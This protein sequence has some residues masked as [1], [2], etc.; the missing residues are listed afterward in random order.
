MFE[1]SRNF[2]TK[3]KLFDDLLWFDSNSLYLVS[4]TIMYQIGNLL[5]VTL[6]KLIVTITLCYLLEYLILGVSLNYLSYIGMAIVTLDCILIVVQLYQNKRKKKAIEQ[7]YE[8]I[9]D[10]DSDNGTATRVTSTSDSEEIIWIETHL[11]S[12]KLM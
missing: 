7:E 4:G 8:P 6:V 11:T 5:T 3:S 1:I 9:K 2:Q 12:T 10:I